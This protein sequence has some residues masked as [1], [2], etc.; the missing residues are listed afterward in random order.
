M[1]P[2]V[3]VGVG[4]SVVSVA[5]PAFV[6]DPSAD[7]AE[8][9]AVQESIRETAT[10]DD[11]FSFDLD[12]VGA[13]APLV[14]GVDQ[15]F[16]D[17]QTVSAVV[18]TRGSAVVERVT[19]VEETTMPYIPGLLSF[20]EGG[21]ALEA[22]QRLSTDPDLLLF[23]GSGRLHPRGAGLAT[24]LGVTLDVPAVGV[25]KNLLCGRLD[26]EPDGRPVGWREPIYA[27]DTGPLPADTLL[28]YAAQTRQYDSRP[29]INPVYVSPGHRVSPATA[30][31]CVQRTCDGYKLPEPIRLADSAAEEAKSDYE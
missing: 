6:P 20:R 26:A 30:L 7:R 3:P 29:I 31:E 16:L 18:L 4:C 22:I 25:A 13:D 12:A 10:F 21:V 8:L 17:E 9:L 24:H 27:D 14:A 2:A 11:R 5:R 15:A 19:A 28:G 23:D 1:G